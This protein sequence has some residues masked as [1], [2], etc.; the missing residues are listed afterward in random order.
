[1]TPGP[2]GAAV[3]SRDSRA[4][5]RV[6]AA[7][8]SAAALLGV[9]AAP[10]AALAPA[11]AD[12]G[13]G[14][15]RHR[16]DAASG[17]VSVH[18]YASG[19][20]VA[21]PSSTVAVTVIVGNT[22]PDRLDIGTV[23]LSI[24]SAPLATRTELGGWLSDDENPPTTRTLKTAATAAVSPG[25]S[26]SVATITLP[27]ADLKLPAGRTAVYGIAAQLTIGGS[28][29]ATGRGSLVWK[30]S[31]A[32]QKTSLAVA[33]PI[34]TPGNTTGLISAS[35]LGAYTAPDGLLT[36]QLDAVSGYPDVA[37]GIDPMIIASIRVLG[38][39][40]PQ[41]ATSWLARLDD[42]SETNEVFA[43]QY[44]DADVAA[45][46]QAGIDE[47]LQPL[48]FGYAL[49]PAKHKTEPTVGETPEPTG[50]GPATPTS[51]PSEPAG[52]PTMEHLLAW[53]YTLSG[54]AWPGDDTVRSAD[55]TALAKGGYPTTIVAGSNTNAARLATTP[56]ASVSVSGAKAL[57]ADTQLSASLRAAVNAA[58]SDAHSEAM[59]TL[60]AQ[61]ELVD[62]QPG[63]TPGR[64]LLA[65]LD[66]THPTSDYIA[67]QTFAA[68][69]DSA[70]S[71]PARLQDAI[72]APVASGVSIADKPEP[73]AR[74]SL[75]HA[76]LGSGLPDADS[77]TAGPQPQAGGERGLTD[78]ATLLSDPTLLT[79]P[80]RNALLALLGV[81]WQNPAADWS[82]AVQ[83][84]LAGARKTIDSVQIA[85]ISP[86]TVT[87]AQ[88][89]IPITVTNEFRLPVNIV[90]RTIPSNPRL[91][92]DA[93]TSKMISAGSS[94]KVVV[95]VKARV[96]NG[97]LQL[98][99]QLLGPANAKT[100]DQFAIGHAQSVPV[101][102]HADWEGIGATVIGIAAVLLFGFGIARA[103][104]RRR[105]ERRTARSASTDER[106]KGGQ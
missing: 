79:G 33:T 99:L 80:T 52:V 89:Q 49:D 2:S 28:S 103:I 56:S 76:L 102:V 82:A 1:V 9:S 64:V 90:L 58:T 74:I 70:W 32:T 88:S 19:D 30:A 60:N 44:G 21:T 47:P 42:L 8:I 63:A 35:D 12:A 68:L 81:G 77:S 14:A 34:T 73:D 31:T 66:R 45:Q 11:G 98:G 18:V 100:G 93:T 83:K 26:T 24:T 71:S 4:R 23:T 59:A 96:G 5:A 101:D 75:V 50:T 78:F 40:A 25:G 85:P 43:L 16:S 51:T 67:S 54:V 36:R 92:I 86:I 37:V 46:V 62:A 7:I 94:G 69:R 29:A 106:P 20:G 41:T 27:A 6:A 87:A 13:S 10:A 53:P 3:V 72:Q 97:K 38:S 15:A 105:R 61:L 95:A 22:T 65:T 91:E 39:E 84:N 17:S 48:S 57:V 104:V 55:I